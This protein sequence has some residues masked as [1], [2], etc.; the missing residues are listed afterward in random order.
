MKTILISA[1]LLFFS[2][3]S[4]SQIY[5]DDFDLNTADG[6]GFIYV[7]LTYKPAQEKFEAAI[8]YG[9]HY[10]P[11]KVETKE[12]KDRK[13]NSLV[14][15]LNFF[16]KNGWELYNNPVEHEKKT[17]FNTRYYLLLSKSK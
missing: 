4:Y 15:A 11:A 16:Y 6:V 14:D 9:D 10:I 3:I 2:Y 13:F 5:I 7:T 1:V 12:G 8:D 17:L